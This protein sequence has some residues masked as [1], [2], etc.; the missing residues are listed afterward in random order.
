[1]AQPRSMSGCAQHPQTLLLMSGVNAACTTGDSFVFVTCCQADSLHLLLQ[2]RTGSD[3]AARAFV[4][5]LVHSAA[6]DTSTLLLKTSC[7]LCAARIP[8]LRIPPACSV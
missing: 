6:G 2:T 8:G 7:M 3:P 4:G 5:L 1:M